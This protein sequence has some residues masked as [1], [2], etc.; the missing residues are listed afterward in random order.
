MFINKK[1]L[2]ETPGTFIFTLIRHIIH[3]TIEKWR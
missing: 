2:D 3:I 1:S